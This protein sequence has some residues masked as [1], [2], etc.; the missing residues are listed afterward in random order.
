MRL[1]NFIQ[2]FPNL[3]SSGAV[4]TGRVLTNG[5]TTATQRVHSTHQGAG[6]SKR[7]L[8]QDFVA[9]K[10]WWESAE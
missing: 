3:Q 7:K 1:S 2:S 10:R 9:N 4:T 5:E 6:N 8:D